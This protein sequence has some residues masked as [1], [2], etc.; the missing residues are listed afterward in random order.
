AEAQ[1]PS[2]LESLLRGGEPLLDAGEGVGGIEHR[3]A[4]PAQLVRLGEHRV[5]V[6]RLP[7]GFRDAA[8]SAGEAR[9]RLLFAL[10]RRAV[11]LERVDARVERGELRLDLVAM[12]LVREAQDPALA[13]VAAVR[14]ATT[15]GGLPRD[16]DGGNIAAELGRVGDAEVVSLSDLPAHPARE[17][18]G[19]ER[20]ASRDEAVVVELG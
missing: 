10:A 11:G 20:Q 19:P 4:L 15:V 14:A 16:R 17:R 8:M 5:R 12:R 7:L 9:D 2:L 18:R 6:D 13:R 1:A 3:R